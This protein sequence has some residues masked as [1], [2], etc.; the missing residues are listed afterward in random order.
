MV[1]GAGGGAGSV[2]GG[3]GGGALV[4]GTVVVVVDEVVVVVVVV[5]AVVVVVRSTLDS[6]NLSFAGDESLPPTTAP[7]A[8]SSTSSPATDPPIHIA[9]RPPLDCLPTDGGGGTPAVVCVGGFHVAAA[10]V[11]DQSG[12]GA[13]AT[14]VVGTWAVVNGLWAVS[15]GYHLPSDASHHPG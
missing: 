10:V 12:C 15:G 1:G 11:G 9:V 6:V 2:V 4:V 3:G 5:V 13:T 8:T 7:I 14:S